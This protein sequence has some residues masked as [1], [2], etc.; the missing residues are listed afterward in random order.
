MT[1]AI[2]IGNG[3]L[4][5]ASVLDGHVASLERIA[6]EPLPD[7]LVLAERIAEHGFDGP[8]GEPVAVVSVVPAIT[9]LVRE[10]VRVIGARLLVADAATIPM[11]VRVA[12]PGRVGPDRLLAAWGASLN[13]TVPLIV[14]DLGTATTVDAVDESGAFVGGA[15]LPGMAL[16]AT[17]LAEATALLPDVELRL[18]G[19]AIGRDTVAALRS[20]VVLGHLGAIRE[21]ATR[22]AAELAPAGPR[23]TVVAT[24]GLTLLPWVREALLRDEGPGLPPIADVVDAELLL[25]SLGRLATHGHPVPVAR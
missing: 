17:A 16:G 19:H 7:P 15:I 5:L 11:T 8:P 2:D 22:I 6:T 24:G 12:H 23:P 21:V 3:A 20:G 25:R 13:R 10:A 1:V 9:D 18:P 4:K 14:V